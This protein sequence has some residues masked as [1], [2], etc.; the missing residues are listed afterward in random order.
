MFYLSKILQIPTV[1]FNVNNRR[2][3]PN[4][5]K[6]AWTFLYLYKNILRYLYFKKRRKSRTLENSL[7]ENMLSKKDASRT[8]V[9]SS[10]SLLSKLN[11]NTNMNI[12]KSSKSTPKLYSH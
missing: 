5:I 10:R 7:M 11:K 8:C 6:I 4:R 9:G 1:F 3:R 2:Y 12:N